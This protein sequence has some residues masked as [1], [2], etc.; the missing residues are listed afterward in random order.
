MVRLFNTNSVGWA[1]V[2]DYGASPTASAATN[3]A[4]FTAAFAAL[5]ATGGVIRV[6]PGEYTIDAVTG[7]VT[8]LSNTGLWFDEGAVLVVEPNN[9]D[10]YHAIMIQDVSNVRIWGVE[11]SGDWASHTG[12]T[13]QWGRG[14]G[15]FA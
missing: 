7:S 9:Q 11:I 1:K 14:I 13:G 4:A 5:G 2:T 6:P 12:V 3:S 10:I 15:I 8:P